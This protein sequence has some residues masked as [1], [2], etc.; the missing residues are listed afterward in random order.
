MKLVRIIPST[1]RNGAI[2]AARGTKH[3]TRLLM[4]TMVIVLGAMP[5][6]S[7]AAEPRAQDAWHVGPTPDVRAICHAGDSLWVGTGAGLF[8]FDIRDP[9][10]R[11]HVGAG[12]GL[13]SNSVRA[14]ASN[15]DSVWVAT[16]AGVTL[17][18]GGKATLFSARARK[19]GAPLRLIQHVAFTARGD[20]ML[21]TRRAGVGVLTRSG[22]YAIT[23]RDSLLDDDVFGVLE[24][25]GRPRLYACA[26]GLCAQI[27]DTTMVSFQAGAGLPRGEVRQ[28]V[29]DARTAYVRV[30][31]RGIFQ[32]DGQHATRVTEPPGVSFVDA[33]SL[34]LGADRALWVAGPG[35]IVVRR[36]GKWDRVKTPSEI[37]P[38]WNVIVADGAGA[39]V[40]SAGGVVLALN[41][42]TGFRAVLDEGLP[43]ATVA[44][45]RPDGRGNAWFVSGG[46][47]VSA[48]A[49]SRQTA[50]E[51]SPLDAEA[52]DFSPS[53]GL[54]VASRWTIARKNESGWAD[55]SPDIDESDP[56]F[57][58]VF[59]ETENVLWAGARSGALYRFDGEVWVRYS[60]PRAIAASVRDARAFSA[61]NW[62]LLGSAPMR[63]LSGYWYNSAGWDSTNVAV[64]VAMSPSGEWFAATGD[65]V[66]RFDAARDAWQPASNTRAL[67]ENAPGSARITSIAFD[68]AGRLFIGTTDGFGCMVKGA[69]RWWNVSD[70]IGG[71]R[72]N[73]LATDA[74]ALWVGYGEDGLS[75]IPLASLR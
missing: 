24:R 34:S 2:I 5:V 28:V 36:N 63:N 50:V 58:A 1:P 6:A 66:F 44:S 52:V 25:E 49:A 17:F 69:T 9:S 8:V 56:A 10:H 19:S 37:A 22:G 45:L 38:S 40:G 72:V 55:L 30:A 18:Y 32:F 47:V 43:S 21:S 54:L 60:R 70:G 73:D 48:N 53:G 46:R 15:G 57:T 31:R 26:A 12:P 61:G 33:T 67:P 27:N 3:R 59:A 74:S 41:R 29:G 11:S 39:F 71:E 75:V 65:R 51:N 16:D 62:A 13:A 4:A 7:L 20:V 64:D 42:G 68:P 23:R 14:I 35:F